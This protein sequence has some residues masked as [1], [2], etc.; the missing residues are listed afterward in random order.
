[1]SVKGSDDLSVDAVPGVQGGALTGIAGLRTRQGW[2][3]RGGACRLLLGH[4]Q[5]VRDEAGDGRRIV[6]RPAGSRQP[7]IGS[8]RPRSFGR[9]QAFAPEEVRSLS[10]AI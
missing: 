7:N 6:R 4:A 9:G 5:Q 10:L 8:G 2:A 1:M 3:A